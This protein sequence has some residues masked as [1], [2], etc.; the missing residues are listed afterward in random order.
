MK[1]IKS[2]ISFA[3]LAVVF[4]GM[5]A[6]CETPKKNAEEEAIE[7]NKAIQEISE[8]EKESTLRNEVLVVHDTAMARMDQIHDLKQQLIT[9]LDGLGDALKPVGDERRKAIREIIDE[10]EGADNGMMSWMHDFTPKLRELDAMS[11]EEAM[12]F[13]KEEMKK[14]EKVSVDIDKAIERAENELSN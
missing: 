1:L 7:D 13:L 2:P 3:L 11:H 12:N 9:A 10:L 14:I 4:F 8:E 6:S 5:L